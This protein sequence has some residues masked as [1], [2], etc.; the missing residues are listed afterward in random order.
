MAMS[1]KNEN[2][3]ITAVILSV[4]S[5]RNVTVLRPAPEDLFA[6]PLTPIGRLMQYRS[7]TDYDHRVRV[8]GTATFYKPGESLILEENGKALFVATT[9]TADIALG[10]RVEAVGFPAAQASGPVLQD[11][12][13]RRIAA[14]APLSPTA[15]E[16][17]TFAPAHSTT[18]SSLRKGSFSDGCAN[19]SGRVAFAK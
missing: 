1:T 3:Q 8:A 13:F 2:R 7:G 15:V 10:D 18:T 11:A 6:K 4:P 9:Q 19:L 14:G 17:P 5:I 12:V 16:L